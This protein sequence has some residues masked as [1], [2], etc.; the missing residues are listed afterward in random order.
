MAK[1]VCELCGSDTFV[2]A[3]G[4]FICQGCN[5]GYTP[6]EAREMMVGE[7]V[8]VSTPISA[9]TPERTG[10]VILPGG[11]NVGSASLG[12]NLIVDFTQGKRGQYASV[13]IDG[14]RQGTI[15]G[16]H[17]KEYSL[18]PGVHRLGIG[19]GMRGCKNPAIVDV[20]PGV[21]YTLTVYVDGLSFGFYVT[22]G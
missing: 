13:I 10:G 3:D 11:S 7:T 22:E 8:D 15:W 14:K 21:L 16:R 18:A 20:A 5:T 9:G 4:M 12:R 6:D 19:G 2:K 17:S 1:I